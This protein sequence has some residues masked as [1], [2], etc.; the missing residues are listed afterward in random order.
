MKKSNFLKVGFSVVFAMLVT[1]GVFGQVQGGIDYAPIAGATVYAAGVPIDS[2]TTGT[3]TRLYTK[4]DPYYHPNYTALGGW[5]L[6]GGFT[7]TWTVP[8]ITG[9]QTAGANSNVWAEIQWGA[10][11]AAPVKIVVTE[12]TPAGFGGC[13]GDTNVWV[14]ILPTPTATFTA[15]NPGSIIGA[16]LTVCEGDPRLTDIVQGTLTGIFNLQLEWTFEIATLNAVGAKVEYWDLAKATLGGAPAFAINRAGTVANPQ[17]TGIDALTFDFDRPTDGDY[18]AIDDGT[19]KKPTLYTYVINGVNDRISRKSDYL[20]NPTAAPQSWS[21][22][23]TTAETIVIRVN[24][25]PV[26][27]PIY[28]IPNTWNY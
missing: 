7:W 6:T 25:A 1:S 17:E 27:G 8:A 14:R 10:V 5:V 24:P 9:T 20:T 26:T 13:S 28:H 15:D 22:Y 23:D 11:N 2:V 12:T 16:D 4:P 3:T 21:W 18:T 19:S